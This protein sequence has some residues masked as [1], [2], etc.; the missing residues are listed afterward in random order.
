[1]WIK[2]ETGFATH[3]KILE[4]GPECLA[5]QIRAICYAAQNQTDGYIPSAA[6]PMLTAGLD[7]ETKWDREMVAYQL[8]DE[9]PDHPNGYFIHDYLDW[10]V[11]KND[12]MILRKKQSQGGKKGMKSRY[13][14]ENKKLTQVT[15][16]DIAQ[17]VSVASISISKSISSLSPPLSSSGKIAQFEQFWLLYPRKVAKGDARKSWKKIVLHN[18]LF[19]KIC[20]QVEAAKQTEQW[21]RD[22]GQ[23]IPYPATWLNQSRWED[24]YSTKT[25][26]TTN[27]FMDR[28]A[29]LGKGE[30]L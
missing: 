24:D 5:L 21:Q 1:M 22:G 30:R 17:P 4:A 27:G 9:F 20:Q 10:N 15:T 12:L 3:P 2:L 11:S 13:S 25:P 7:E 8:W 18:G 14:Q 16:T 23:F 29:K 28:M 6:I 19:E 26:I